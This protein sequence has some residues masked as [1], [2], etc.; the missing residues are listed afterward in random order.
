MGKVEAPVGT[1]PLPSRQVARFKFEVRGAEEE[2]K[3]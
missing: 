2:M 1:I 3:N